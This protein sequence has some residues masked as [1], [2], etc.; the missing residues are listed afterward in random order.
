MKKI[1]CLI[2]GHNQI[3]GV[4]C[5]KTSRAMWGRDAQFYKE[6]VTLRFMKYKG[7]LYTPTQASY[8]FEPE[9]K[10]HFGAFENISYERTLN[11]AV[12]YLTNYLNGQGFSVDY[13]NCFKNGREKLAELLDSNCVE[14]I[15]ISSSIYTTVFPILE[16]TT[17][18]KKHNDKV[19]IVVGGPYISNQ[20]RGLEEP[21]L[22]KLF[23]RMGAD[24]YIYDNEGEATL[25][26][27][28]KAMKENTP[29][30]SINN[31]FYRDGDKYS[32]TYPAEEANDLESNMVDW[33]LFQGT[34]FKY[35]N[36]RTAI[37]CPFAC[38]F[39]GY[40]KYTGRYRQLSVEA[41]ERELDNIKKYTN[42][43]GIYFIDDTFN[44]PPERFKS[45]LRTII[46]KKYNFKWHSFFRCQF[47]DREMVELMKESGCQIVYCGIESANQTVLDNMNKKATTE[48]YRAG[49]NLL[50]E[51]GIASVASLIIGFP[52][53]THETY[54]ETYNFIEETKPTFFRSH[55]WYADPDSPIYNRKSE[56]NLEGSGY[57]WSHATMDSKTAA[58]LSDRMFLNIKNS[59]YD[60]DY[61]VAFD[62]LLRGYS[63]EQTKRFINGF[64]LC[65]KEHVLNPNTAES[66]PE[67]IKIMKDALRSA[68]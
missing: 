63:I 10:D 7:N 1:D 34:N 36:V 23:G 27:V 21:E 22:Q 19:K 49:M 6:A 20:V 57:D 51:Y 18:I 66:N 48:Q 38:A 35:Y 60:S 11:G 47:A 61:P 65:L 12:A 2:I 26:K 62:L 37:S 3:T 8:M 40:P 56:F 54:M 15:A 68:N 5:E 52:G 24:A 58:E 55:L 33:S 50:N 64:D 4:K 29:L 53:E 43:Q 42:V 30:S 17:F 9:V 16:I 45:I 31:L 28:L 41:I 25:V 32:F 14:T 44:F 59:V 46:K 39:C 13:I 67:Y